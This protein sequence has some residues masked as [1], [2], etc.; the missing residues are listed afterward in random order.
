MGSGK[1]MQALQLNFSLKEA[2]FKP[3][4]IKPRTDTRTIG[5]IKSRIGLE[6]DC[7][8]FPDDGLFE[9]VEPDVTHVICDEAQFLTRDQVLQ[10][11]EL[12]DEHAIAVYCFGLR[13]SYTGELFEGSAALFALADNLVELPLIYKD[14][15]KTIMH[16]RYIDGKPVF[17]GNPVH[18]GDIKEDYESVSRAQYF[19][20]KK[21]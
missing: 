4:L 2:G 12:V 7:M 8:I 20:L 11:V 13:T 6:E 19:N 10:F 17:D 14:G 15:R 21:K 18:V 16:V 5:T 3:L 9:V 1:S